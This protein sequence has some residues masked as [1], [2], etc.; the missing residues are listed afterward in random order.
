[1]TSTPVSNPVPG[2]AVPCPTEDEVGKLL[3]LEGLLP[4]GS[5]VHSSVH[6]PVIHSE[7]VPHPRVCHHRK[8]LVSSLAELRGRGGR[9]DVRTP[10]GL[11]GLDAFHPTALQMYMEASGTTVL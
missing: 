10:A 3:L 8:I 11:A 2:H 5:P 4:H 1:M 9:G 7:S 6:L